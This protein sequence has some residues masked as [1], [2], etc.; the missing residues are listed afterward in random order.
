MRYFIAVLILSTAA[1]QAAE[2]PLRDLED[3][4]AASVPAR[5]SEAIPVTEAQSS[6]GGEWRVYRDKKGKLTGL[7]RADLGESGRAEMRLVFINAKNFAIRRTQFHYNGH[8]AMD[9][10]VAVVREE[11]DIFYFC[12]G[13]LYTLTE[14]QAM[15]GTDPAYV[16]AAAEARDA[17]WKAPEIAKVLKEIR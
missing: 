2:C 17:I 13:K 3:R 11:S 6:E 7:V 16:K 10:P 15:V 9:F 4:L 12:S 8:F 5:E 1:A 14:E